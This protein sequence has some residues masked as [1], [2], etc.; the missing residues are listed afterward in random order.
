MTMGSD[1]RTAAETAL[2]ALKGVRLAQTAVLLVSALIGVLLVV[3]WVFWR[4]AEAVRK[5]GVATVEAIAGDTTA[6]IAV[7]AIPMIVK[8]ERQKVEIRVI[9]QEGQANVRSAPDAATPIA[10]VSAAMRTTVCVLHDKERAA[11]AAGSL[12]VDADCDGAAGPNASNA[13]SPD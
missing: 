3:W 5:E 13:S 12:P 8:T 2:P 10:G 11:G 4:P 9:T 1:L 7:E 6:R